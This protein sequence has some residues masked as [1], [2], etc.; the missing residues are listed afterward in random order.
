MSNYTAPERIP[1]KHSITTRLLLLVISIYLSA[2]ILLTGAHMWT[3]YAAV[4]NS[5]KKDLQSLSQLVT[6]TLANAV[7]NSNASSVEETVNSLMSNPTIVGVSI[8]AG[9]MGHFKAGS[10]APENNAALISHTSPII[11]PSPSGPVPVGALTVCS[12]RYII[13]EKVW[14][15][16]LMILGNAL[17]QAIVLCAA[18]FLL[19]KR[20]VAQPLGRLTSAVRELDMDNLHHISSDI[21]KRNGDELKLLE[22]AFNNMI[23]T[24]LAARE[25]SEELTSD[26][27]QAGHRLKDYSRTLELKVQERTKE[28][29][30]ALKQV[31]DAHERAELASQAKSRFLA[32]MSHEIRTPLNAIVGMPDILAETKLTTEQQQYVDIFRTSGDAL[33]SIINDILDFSRIE[34]GQ[35]TLERMA[36]NLPEVL[37]KVCSIQSVAAHGKGL[38]IGCSIDPAVPETVEGD[39]TRLHQML[40]NLLSNAVKF[41][42]EGEVELSVA[43]A[44]GGIHDGLAFSVRDTGIGIPDDKKPYVFESFTQGDTSTPRLYGGSGLGLSI[45]KRIATLMGGSIKVED[46]PGG[47]SI[48]R[49]TAR[50]GIPDKISRNY[51]LQNKQALVCAPT[52][53]RRRTSASALRYLGASVTQT[54]TSAEAVRICT[55]HNSFDVVYVDSEMLNDLE[56]VTHLGSPLSNRVVLIGS[57]TP[58][59]TPHIPDSGPRTIQYPASSKRIMDALT[60]QSEGIHPNHQ[61]KHESIVPL[62]I[63]LAEDQ[64]YNQKLIRFFLEET[65]HRLATADNG[66]EALDLFTNG[67]FDI[68]FMDMEM[69]VM[70]GYNATRAIRKYEKSTDKPPVPVIALTAHAFAEHVTMST[71]AGCDA[72]LSKPVK[73]NDFLKT[74]LYYAGTTAE[75]IDKR[76]NAPARVQVTQAM[77]PIAEEFLDDTIQDSEIIINA[78]K[79][80]DTE[81]IRIKGHSLKGAGSGY[82]FEAIT[83]LGRDIEAAAIDMD[84]DKASALAEQLQN[85]AKTVAIDSV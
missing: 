26:L 76:T 35:I 28:L 11:Y 47:G 80:G 41:T 20:L 40:T 52:P 71:E 59:Q 18:L 33:L 36:F 77:R 51:P 31:R 2:A 65:P 22:D 12:S 64:Q 34:C 85:Y 50:F 62:S 67:K 16:F 1:F 75:R 44:P 17:L 78:A 32:S 81:T 53:L 27:R 10:T 82:G 55:G 84:F 6:P 48:F 66:Q 3:Q 8:S 38:D 61:S 39:P 19:S 70:D 68:V 24:L 21:S 79:T 58:S 74:L 73:K 29:H 83:E 4:S 7:F 60:D 14:H 54:E 49:F 72:H 42:E 45:I 13:L 57:K 43:P 56:L 25:K 9:P 69:P 5:V 15:S 63:L 23:D 30:T 46:A 37:D